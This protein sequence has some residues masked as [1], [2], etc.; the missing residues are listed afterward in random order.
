MTTSHLIGG[1]E[2][3]DVPK[4]FEADTDGKIVIDKILVNK[5]T[6]AVDNVYLQ[7]PHQSPF[8]NF[9]DK[10]GYALGSIFNQQQER[11]SLS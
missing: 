9:S 3:S 5:L 10:F 4:D 7:C 11:Y 8:R 1:N 6:L 2:A